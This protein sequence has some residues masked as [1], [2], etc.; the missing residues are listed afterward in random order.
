VNNFYLR[1]KKLKPNTKIAPYALERVAQLAKGR[2]NFAQ[3]TT[4]SHLNLA[5]DGIEP[6]H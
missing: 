3:Y 2:S 6:L 5:G 4:G 1:D